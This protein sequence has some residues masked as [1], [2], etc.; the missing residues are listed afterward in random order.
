MTQERKG[1]YSIVAKELRTSIV[2]N[3]LPDLS[4]KGLE[5]SLD[6]IMVHVFSSAN[7]EVKNFARCLLLLKLEA[8]SAQGKNFIKYYNEAKLVLYVYPEHKDYIIESLDFI[9]YK[10]ILHCENSDVLALAEEASSLGDSGKLIS[11]REASSR[12]TQMIWR[13]INR[14]LVS[15][16]KS[17]GL[18]LISTIIKAE[19]L[20]YDMSI[21]KETAAR[22]MLDFI[23]K[24]NGFVIKEEEIKHDVQEDHKLLNHIKMFNVTESEIQGRL[25][26]LKTQV[27]GIEKER[28]ELE[29]SSYSINEGC[30]KYKILEAVQLRV[31]NSGLKF[32]DDMPRYSKKTNSFYVSVY[33]AEY[34]GKEA[35]VKIYRKLSPDVDMTKVYNEC[36]IY[37]VLGDKAN[38]LCN[39]F[40]K[41]YGSYAQGDSIC[42]VMEYI[43]NDLMTFLTLI[44][45]QGGIITDLQ[46]MPIMKKLIESF[47]EMEELG[48]YHGD[49]KP[50]NILVDNNWNLK[51]ID[52][53]ISV[54]NKEFLT[55]GT[56]S[57]LHPLQGTAGYMA[58]EI[59]E[60]VKKGLKY[61]VF[62]MSRAD[63]F[64]LGMT[65]LQ[66]LTLADYTGYNLM[67]NNGLLINEVNKLPYPWARIMLGKMLVADPNSRYKFKDLLND[68][69]G[70]YK[71]TFIQ[72]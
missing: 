40:L 6:N 52:F 13:Y 66:M 31:I 25:I 58:P 56:T 19:K 24:R 72:Q 32:V 49:I 62:K 42:L 39:A 38:P 10:E 41:Y 4:K 20:H 68:F 5:S 46:L 47:A 48:I 70:I 17:N 43:E 36:K 11:Q 34:L 8:E 35:A 16:K 67:E 57:S 51:I 53:S 15:P 23:E 65:F 54:V 37:Q 14:F 1:L 21:I 63:V 33:K 2:Q 30:E 29:E 22:L 12:L 59:A 28:P 45:Q 50:H 69:T 26:D 18:R 64:S 27:E 71:E 60:G 55:G 44:K 9:L 7:P 3:D 61:D